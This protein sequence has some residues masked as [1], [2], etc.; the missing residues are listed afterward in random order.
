MEQGEVGENFYI[1][2]K[3]SVNVII[4]GVHMVTLDKE[5]TGFG[6]LALIE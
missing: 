5:G 3:G 2:L 1:I 6:E 4:N